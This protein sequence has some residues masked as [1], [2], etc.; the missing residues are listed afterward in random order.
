LVAQKLC[1]IISKKKPGYVL[2]PIYMG[3]DRKK[4]VAGE[5][6]VGMDRHVGKKLQG[7]VYYLEPK[8]F[9][10][11]IIN[12]SNNLIDQGFE[13][14]ILVTGHAGSGQIKALKMAK[15]KVKNLSVCNPYETLEKNGINIEHAD[16]NET[17]LFWACYPEEE[18]GI[19]KIKLK[20]DDDYVKFLGYD[21]REKASMSLGKKMLKIVIAGME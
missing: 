16:E 10:E 1:E 15:K 5:L 21:P 14:I 18:K 19:R 12:L 4:K 6:L 11:L 3:S 7:S 2:P 9:S 17:S 13:K 8:F 20:K